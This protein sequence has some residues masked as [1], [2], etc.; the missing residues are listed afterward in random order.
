MSL[1]GI[2]NNL[3]AMERAAPNDMIDIIL[4]NIPEAQQIHLAASY[5][6]KEA[7]AG[8]SFFTHGQEFG[9]ETVPENRDAMLDAIRKA[10]ELVSSG[11]FT[12]AYRAE[13]MSQAIRNREAV[14]FRQAHDRQAAATSWKPGL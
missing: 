7:R 3:V 2:G 4:P 9:I 11:Q 10:V 13:H 1:H 5:T 14:E 12:D 6:A 8:G